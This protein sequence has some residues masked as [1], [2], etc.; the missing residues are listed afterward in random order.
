MVHNSVFCHDIFHCGI[1]HRLL[2]VLPANKWNKL[3]AL[4]HFQRHFWLSLAAVCEEVVS[5]PFRYWEESKQQDSLFRSRNFD[6]SAPHG[7]RKKGV[8]ITFFSRSSDLAPAHPLSYDLIKDR[9]AKSIGFWRFTK[10]KWLIKSKFE[11][12]AQCTKSFISTSW[13]Y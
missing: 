1:W 8:E 7:P 6:K 12:C 3:L 9:V 11:S 13:T 5:I 2:S 4:F 10:T